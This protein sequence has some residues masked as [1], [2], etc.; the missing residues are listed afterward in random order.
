MAYVRCRCRKLTWLASLLP[1][2]WFLHG[3]FAFV[4]CPMTYAIAPSYT[5][6]LVAL[7]H[8]EPDDQEPGV[9]EHARSKV[10]RSHRSRPRDVAAELRTYG[11]ILLHYFSHAAVLIG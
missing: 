11:Y 3:A 6:D 1:E 10:L 4:D 8:V 7:E 5:E 2:I 9:G